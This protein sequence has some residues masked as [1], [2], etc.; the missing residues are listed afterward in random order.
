M[1]HLLLFH[2]YL[3]ASI[4]VL[5]PLF[6]KFFSLLKL[7]IINQRSSM[8]LYSLLHNIDIQR[9]FSLFFNVSYLLLLSN[10]S[11]HCLPKF[12]FI[13]DLGLEICLFTIFVLKNLLFSQFLKCFISVFKSLD[14]FYSGVSYIFLAQ[15]TIIFYYISQRIEI[16]KLH[17]IIQIDFH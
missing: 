11:H 12:V 6:V 7:F 3:V 1:K 8:L 4:V 13:C 17:T 15:R 9:L 10:H 16:S 14:C 5:N 2:I